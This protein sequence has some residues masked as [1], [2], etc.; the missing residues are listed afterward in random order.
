MGSILVV[1]SECRRGRWGY[2][3]HRHQ[4]AGDDYPGFS[5]P[6]IY[7]CYNT[8]VWAMRRYHRR[9]RLDGRNTM[10]RWKYLYSKFTV[11]FAVLVNRGREVC[12]ISA[13]AVDLVRGTTSLLYIF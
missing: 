7:G 5:N 9:C 2:R 6:N 13:K 1:R 4:P 12:V 3:Y 11:L 8:E 10:R